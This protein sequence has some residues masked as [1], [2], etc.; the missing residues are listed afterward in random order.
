MK[1]ELIQ[2]ITED[3]LILN[4]LY[5]DGDKNKPVT[6][7]IHGFTSDFYSHKFFL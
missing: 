2:T 4:G 5:L 7:L 3:E 6:I 1:A